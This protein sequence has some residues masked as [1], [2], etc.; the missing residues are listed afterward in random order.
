MLHGVAKSKNKK[1][2]SS[3]IRDNRKYDDGYK[4]LEFCGKG[5]MELRN[6]GS[7]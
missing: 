2:G 6:T 1:E 3:R 7:I 4:K 5:V